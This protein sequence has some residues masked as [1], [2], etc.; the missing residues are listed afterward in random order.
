VLRVR[1]E[2]DVR[3]GSELEVLLECRCQPC[4]YI[5]RKRSIHFEGRINDNQLFALRENVSVQRRAS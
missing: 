5:I 4:V 1:G 2:S 3:L